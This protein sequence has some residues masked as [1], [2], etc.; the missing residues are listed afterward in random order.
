MTVRQWFGGLAVL[1]FMS[2]AFAGDEGKLEFKAFNA[3]AQP[4]YQELETETV[5]NM[6]VMGQEVTQKQNQTFYIQWTP[7]TEKDAKD[8]TVQEKIVGVKMNIDI[9]GNKIAYDSTDEKQSAN[10]MSDFFNALKSL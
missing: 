5:Q 2:V 6:K 1:A 7:K 8:W 3:G 4:F 9:G 10:P